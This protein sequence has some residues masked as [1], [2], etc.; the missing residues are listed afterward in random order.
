MMSGRLNLPKASDVR[1]AYQGLLSASRGKKSPADPNSFSRIVTGDGALAGRIN[2]DGVLPGFHPTTSIH[3]RLWWC[4]RCDHFLP[5]IMIIKGGETPDAWRRSNKNHPAQIT[6]W[7]PV[8]FLVFCLHFQLSHNT[9][10]GN[11]PLVPIQLLLTDLERLVE[12]S[13]VTVQ[14]NGAFFLVSTL[15]MREEE[16]PDRY[17]ISLSENPFVAS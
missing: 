15:V 7:E 1:K 8:Y 14:W 6:F 16:K 9:Y 3:S 12:R 11:L 17:Q 13:P 4:R 5:F 10:H 2:G